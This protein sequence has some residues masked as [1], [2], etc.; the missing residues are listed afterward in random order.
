MTG[1]K[2]ILS[3]F[4]FFAAIL[5]GLVFVSTAQATSWYQ[6]GTLH[7][8][9]A[10]EWQKASRDNKVATCADILASMYEK[11]RLAPSIVSSLK[12]IDDFKPYALKLADQLDQAFKPDPNVAKNKK[13]F[14][15]QTVSETA[16]MLLILMKW[17][18]I[19]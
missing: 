16:A 15:N 6:G 11:K 9:T 10:L 8:A 1:R 17:T 13:L 14:A 3:R 19:N 18:N 12:S 2:I 5:L 4:Y 7:N